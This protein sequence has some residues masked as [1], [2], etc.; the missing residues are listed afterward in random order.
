MSEQ[1]KRMY[2]AG[3]WWLRLQENPD[4][5]SAGEWLSW[6]Q[7]DPANL[8][9][10]DR[11]DR[12]AMT[13]KQLDPQLRRQLA[14]EFAPAAASP[15]VTA[16][17]SRAG[18]RNPVRASWWLATAAGVAVVALGAFLLRSLTGPAPDAVYATERALHQNVTLADGSQVTIGA[19]TVVAVSMGEQ[20]RRIQLRDGEAYFEVSKDVRRPFV[21]DVGRISVTAIGTAFNVRR[22]GENVA[23]S[24]TEGRVRATQPAGDA[25]EA[26]AGE[27]ILYE[28]EGHR[29]R[30]TH[31]SPAR[32]VAWRERR[33]EFVNE[34]LAVVIANLNRYVSSQITFSDPAA[35]QLTF[36]GTVSPENTVAWLRA[37]PDVLPVRVTHE[38]HRAA[39]GVK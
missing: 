20:E 21:V 12:E 7:A 5:A 22:T 39:I 37:L 15:A 1:D 6:A 27:R 25:V 30:L 9:A 28:P 3:Q 38:D 36:T 35:A 33:L 19:S 4:A 24:V 18:R 8:D 10:F 13:Y 14:R 17:A 34:P 26:V 23:I 32:A 16:S 2:E 29:F 11:I 31:V